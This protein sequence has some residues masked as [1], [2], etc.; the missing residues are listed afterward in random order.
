MSD[1]EPEPEV[2]PGDDVPE[3]PEGWHNIPYPEDEYEDDA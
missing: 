2:I 1:V 3:P